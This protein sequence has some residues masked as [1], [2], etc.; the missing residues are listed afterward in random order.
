[1]VPCVSLPEHCR[2]SGAEV[3]SAAPQPGHC[4]VPHP[5]P[6][7][8]AGLLALT[9]TAPFPVGVEL[10]SWRPGASH[11][12]PRP[13][14]RRGLG[15][16]P[17]FSQIFPLISMCAGAGTGTGRALK[18]KSNVLDNVFHFSG[19]QTCLI[20]FVIISVIFCLFEL[21]QEISLKCFVLYLAVL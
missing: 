2:Q 21:R 18:V 9:A 8:R 7:T 19:M 12:G 17:L 6:C 1:M 14:R 15:P 4:A 13:R 20:V 10:G 3:V 11:S 16:T 5:H